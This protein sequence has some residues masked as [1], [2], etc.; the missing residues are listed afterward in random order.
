MA[1][2]PPPKKQG[3]WEG[4]DPSIFVNF[5]PN[6]LKKISHIS[7]QYLSSNSFLQDHR[8]LYG[9]KIVDRKKTFPF[10]EPNSEAFR[11]TL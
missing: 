7:E 5:Q 3:F 1:S 4:I 11:I 9:S 6:G 2:D 10:F 8:I